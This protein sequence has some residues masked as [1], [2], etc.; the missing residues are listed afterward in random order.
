MKL[1]KYFAA[2]GVTAVFC[3]AGMNWHYTGSVLPAKRAETDILNTA[4]YKIKRSIHEAMPRGEGC[5]VFLGDSLTDYVPFSELVQ[6]VRAVNRGIAGDNTLGALRRID[7]IISLKPAKLF[8]LL[9]T[10][11]IVYNMTADTTAANLTAII[12]R[13]QE[14]SPSTK[15]FL[16]TI[17]PTNPNFETH[18]PNDVINALN[19]RVRAVA[20]ET[21]VELADTHSHMAEGGVLPQ[22]WTV[23]GLHLNGAG[24]VR[25]VEFLKPLM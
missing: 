13:V 20:Q 16:E 19:V 23:D 12:R 8:I 4:F 21:G 3:V 17:M 15:I 18:R 24:V 11:D 25:W 2:V 14:A 10:N 7:G 6:G 5:V 1:L 9:G 22:K